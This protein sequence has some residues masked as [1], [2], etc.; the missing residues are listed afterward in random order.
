MLTKFE[1][2]SNRVK[3]LA[4]HPN[5]PWILA[6]LHNG[7][8][9]LWDYRM[10][11]LIDRFDEHEGPVRGVHFHPSQPLFVSGGDDYKIKVWNYKLRRC[12]FTLGGHLDY[13]RTVFF[14]HESPWIV[15]ASDDQT[16]R[17]WNWQNRSCLSILTG[18]NHYV[19]CAQFHPLD[20]LIVSASLDQT[21]RVWD[22][23]S[24][25]QRSPAGGDAAGDMQIRGLINQ[26][27]G[28]IPAAVNA[29]IFGTGDAVVKYLLEGHSRG[30][31]WVSFHPTLPLIIS[32]ADD[33]QVKLWR[34]SE[35]S[36]WEVDTF[37]GHLNNVSC[38]LFHPRQD[39]VISDGEDKTIRV[40]DQNRRTCLHT[41]RKESDRFWI[42]AVHPTTNLIA[43]GHDTG[44][45]VFKLQRERPPFA[46]NEGNL[47][48]V[49][50]SYIRSMN[51]DTARDSPLLMIQRNSNQ[52][53]G[54][55]YGGSLG[56]MYGGQSDTPPAQT[57]P[58][59]SMSYN[60][61]EHCILLNHV[62][63][64]GT[65]EL[66][67]L[68]RGAG[69]VS[70]DTPAEPR[71]GEGIGACF[72]GRNRI[73]VLDRAR[74]NI[75]I[76]D[77]HN[78]TTKRV[79]CLL[80]GAD[81]LFPAGV[82]YVL[83]KNEEKVI[84]QDLQQKKIVAEISAVNVK[85]VVWSDDMSR[86]ALLGKH[87]LVI[88]TRRLEHL[89]TVHETV[90][91]KSAAWD[92]SG[93]IVYSTL[94]H[95]KYCL[96]N[97]DNG[98][99]N[100][101]KDPVYVTRVRGPAVCY[102]DRNA[103]P[104]IF[105]I[106]PT[107]YAFKLMLLRKRYD[108]VRKMITENRLCGKAIIAYLQRKGF[109]EVALHFVRDERTRFNLAVDSGA[110]DIALGAAQELD[111]PE[112]WSTLAGA[113]LKLGN[114]DVV[115]LCYQRTK[116][117]ERLAF[118][119]VLLGDKEK[120]AK[121][122]NIAESSRNFM[123]KF[124]ICMYLGD[125]EG[126]L[127]VLAECGQLALARVMAKAHGL[128]DMIKELGEEEDGGTSVAKG[129]LLPRPLPL[130]G[131]Q[132]WPTLPV[133]RG[134]FTKDPHAE[135]FEEISGDYY[136]DAAALEASERERERGGWGEEER[137]ALG[138]QPAAT[139][140][141]PF[142]EELE[143][144][145]SPAVNTGGDG[146]GDD[147]DD[148]DF[149]GD[150]V[151]APTPAQTGGDDFEVDAVEQAVQMKDYFVPPPPGPGVTVRWTRSAKLVG[152]LVAAGAFDDAMKL[153]SR[154]IGCKSFAAFDDVFR[155]VYLG[156]RASVPGLVNM[157][158]PM[159][160]MSRGVD[161]PKVAVTLESVTNLVH[162]ARDSFAARK[163]NDAKALFSTVA[164]SVPLLVLG[165]D[166]EVKEAVDM[167][168]S[169]R[170][171]LLALACDRCRGEA[172][173]AGN[174]AREVQLAAMFTHCE[175]LPAHKILALRTAMKIAFDAKCFIFAS[176]F[177]RR[178]IDGNPNPPSQALKMIQYCDQNMTNA[179][180]VDYDDRR[181]FVVEASQLV[182]LY[183]G[184]GRKDCSYCKANYRPECAGST[185][186]LCEIG[187]VGFSAEGLRVKTS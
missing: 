172:K 77:L 71:K 61:Q 127:S 27:R 147:L 132:S 134:L 69:G 6:S 185:C 181:D 72:V 84:L 137:A 8:I 73:A 167:L 126:A 56:E 75:L 124:Q 32:G 38:T 11:T 103:I 138:K 2:Q 187:S 87:I 178:L 177:A 151:Q 3:G 28:N 154:Q 176:G 173:A 108:D 111:E 115:E 162:S 45:I 150:E 171:Y 58:A 107:E 135:D 70:G 37:R 128:T 98:I 160:H 16:V 47:F 26:A 179:H 15:S 131:E 13:I 83:V 76:K 19:M 130:S 143:Q 33:R 153:L 85:Y 165:T 52:G 89:A 20:D 121:M 105:A 129:K 142:A 148:F 122:A 31:N 46:T 157:P 92:E 55:A 175:L 139:T 9:Q 4:F 97:G 29:D 182:P 109:P 63:N 152:D 163:F 48:F 68:P 104:G 12:V 180:E 34:I 145:K 117:L 159:V 74:N 30:V 23:S 186:T 54:N 123:A 136:E 99:I 155:S 66:Y 125:V 41:F 51:F 43:A 184:Q 67:F 39:L 116:D 17:V 161:Q 141:D 60:S 120:A 174:T 21:I 100:T 90:R 156:C 183:A 94:N 158:S 42:L 40:W 166:K 101:L 113:A 5:R 59:R 96:P 93:V 78:E 82:G 170:E 10:G 49:K 80:P 133:T 24:L 7:S 88:A 149:G 50:E 168:T 79:K 35:T 102:I 95:L 146:W 18:H 169:S 44:M 140:V 110:I 25:R 164:A 91:I 22:I 119:Y 114:I 36:A 106:D 62:S 144:A 65:Y 57:T 53:M 1:T 81:W 86:V 118:L 14:H 64:G 112:I